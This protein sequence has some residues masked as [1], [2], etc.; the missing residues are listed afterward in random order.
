MKDTVRNMIK[1]E[2]VTR[3]VQAGRGLR[4]VLIVDRFSRLLVHVGLE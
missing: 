1:F 2:F 3:A 4:Q